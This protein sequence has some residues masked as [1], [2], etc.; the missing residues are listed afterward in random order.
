MLFSGGIKRRK[1]VAYYRHSAEDKQENSVPL[2]RDFVHDLLRK[3]DI[4]IIHEEADEGVSGL[5]AN[6][7][8]FS[9]L[10]K[11]WILNPS[12]PQFD[13][14]V[15]YDVSRWGRFEDADEAGYYEFQCKQLGKE[16]VYARRG[17]S[18]ED[19]RGTTQMQTAFERW[20]SFQ[21]S[22]KLSEDVIRGCLR[23]SSQGYV[24]G[25]QAPYGLARLLLSA[26]DRTPI[27]VLRDGEHK[28]V[29]N[30]R[31]IFTPKG[32][33]TTKTVLRI[34][35]LFSD[36]LDP[37]EISETL[38]NEGTRSPNDSEWDKGKVLRILCNPVYKGTL[39]YNKTWGRLYKKKRDNPLSHW[40]V[41]DNAFEAIIDP[42]RFDAVQEQ[43]YW[44]LPSRHRKGV[45]AICRA[46][47]IVKTEI[48]KLLE[49]NGIDPD[50]ACFFPVAF[51]V[52]RKNA[53]QE[54]FWC[55]CI[56]ESLREHENILCVSV[57]LSSA[58]IVDTIFLIPTVEF[59]ARG[60]LL[61]PDTENSFLRYG[62]KSDE[63]E[64]TIVD[65]VYN[66]MEI[67]LCSSENV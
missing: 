42:E 37:K 26:G 55:F 1:A 21:Y 32:D 36:R 18:T 10:F 53:A 34:F 45:H 52:K 35:D 4:D 61:L 39:I 16:V 41:C 11:D 60:M 23:I 17:F 33:H 44:L 20:M 57:N 65:A 51:A 25:G 56:P 43:L 48:K 15:V 5:T 58:E 3:H 64:E 38:N 24:V 54:G 12:A 13:Y 9:R 46:K 50:Y 28:C 47:K 66:R 40:V 14:V 62:E 19:Q 30:E 49:K 31:I 29:A 63:L 7:P 2:Q 67:K 27:R 6:R 8:G 59:D 22:K